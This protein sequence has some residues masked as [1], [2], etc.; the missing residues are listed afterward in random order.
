MCPFP[1]VNIICFSVSFSA[2][3]F[4]LFLNLCHQLLLS[5][6]FAFLSTSLSLPWVLVCPCKHSLVSS[7]T[8]YFL[9]SVLYLSAVQVIPLFL[10]KNQTFPQNFSP[11]LLLHLPS[12]SQIHTLP[13]PWL[14]TQLLSRLLMPFCYQ[15]RLLTSFPP[16]AAFHLAF[17]TPHSQLSSLSG[18]FTLSPFS[19]S[20]SVYTPMLCSCGFSCHLDT[21]ESRFWIITQNSLLT[22]DWILNPIEALNS[23]YQSL[24]PFG[25]NIPSPAFPQCY[26]IYSPLCTQ[27]GKARISL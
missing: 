20:S 10:F 17:L 27:L 6:E 11:L 19:S 16:L 2:S 5:L 3:F 25:P 21:C 7:V 24:D 8:E 14:Q 23:M 4:H 22:E 12:H 18:S 13:A 15:I 26:L 9:L 1:F